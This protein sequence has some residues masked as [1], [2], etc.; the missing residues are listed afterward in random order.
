[1]IFV[2][3]GMH[4]KGFDRLVKKM[5]EIAGNIDEEVILQTGGTDFKPQN[6]KWF[7]FTTEE[8]IRELC[9]KASVVVTHAAMS[10]LDALEQGTPVVVVPRMKV[11]NEVIDDHQLDFARELEKDG[12]AFAVYNVDKLE[13]ALTRANVKPPKL[14]NDKRLIN[15]LRRYIA[16]FGQ[17][18]EEG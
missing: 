12:K 2:T 15:A 4:T 14:I 18:R 5:D 8:E 16:Q 3:V 11:Y 9:R 17:K 7:D 10:V 6:A 13:E 1:L